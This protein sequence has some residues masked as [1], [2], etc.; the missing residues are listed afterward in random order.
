MRLM[1]NLWASIHA[2]TDTRGSL[3]THRGAMQADDVGQVAHTDFQYAPGQLPPEFIPQ[4][5]QPSQSQQQSQSQSQS[6]AGQAE[7]SA[8]QEYYGQSQEYYA[9]NNEGGGGWEQTDAA[10]Y[11]DDGGPQGIPLQQPNDDGPC[12]TVPA[13]SFRQPFASLVLYGVKQL[14]ARNRPQL[15]QTIGPL[16]LHI[17]HKEEPF[18]SPL[19]N[20]AVGLLRRRY[21]DSTIS[22][23]FALPQAHAEGFGCIVGL[24]DV[25]ATWPADLFN[26]VE[27]QQLTEQAVFPVGGTFITQLRNPRWLK[28]PVRTSGSNRLWH[29]QLPIDCLPEGTEL[30]AQGKVMCAYPKDRPPLYQP[31]THAHVNANVLDGDEQLAAGLLGGDMVRALPPPPLRR[32]ACPSPPPAR[33]PTRAPHAARRYARSARRTR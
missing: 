29:V 21:P 2:P 30:D 6:Q 32:A 25:E 5:Q 26:E 4:S 13:L 15:K 17:S 27:Q 22:Q 19:V 14:E 24:V 1:F 11:D 23:L 12:V 20:T 33:E 28:Y 16:A 8:Q 9:Y 7:Y 10:S 3:A 31:G 18:G